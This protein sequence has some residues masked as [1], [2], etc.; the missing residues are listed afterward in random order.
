MLEQLDKLGFVEQT[1]PADT[2][3]PPFPQIVTH[4][5]LPG[6]GGESPRTLRAQ[7]GENRY[8]PDPLGIVLVYKF[9]F[10]E[11]FQVC[12]TYGYPLPGRGC[13]RR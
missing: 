3:A 2:F 13:H 11:L 1:V 8:A 5:A 9:R 6:I 7:V 12:Y 4:P 10:V